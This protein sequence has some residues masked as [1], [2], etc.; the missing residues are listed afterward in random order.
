MSESTKKIK[1]ENVSLQMEIS[2]PPS[3]IK[4]TSCPQVNWGNFGINEKNVNAYLGFINILI[5]LNI[6]FLGAVFFDNKANYYAIDILGL[7]TNQVTTIIASF[8]FIS[9]FACMISYLQFTNL[10]ADI[11]KLTNC[12]KLIYAIAIAPVIFT[13]E[14]FF[15]ITLQKIEVEHTILFWIQLG[16]SLILFIPIILYILSFIKSFIS[17]HKNKEQ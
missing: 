15:T 5:M 3:N 13:L 6:V 1:I 4:E 9:I 2:E 11:N 12:K 17:N 8:S 16:I 10:Q 14:L 7:T